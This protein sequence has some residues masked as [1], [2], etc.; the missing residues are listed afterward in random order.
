MSKLTKRITAFSL[1]CLI[2]IGIPTLFG[3]GFLA[4]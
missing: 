1:A 4:P 2:V 3:G